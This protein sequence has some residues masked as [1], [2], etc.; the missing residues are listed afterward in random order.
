MQSDQ[1]SRTAYRVAEQRAAHQV[2]DVPQRT[3]REVVE[4]VDLPVFA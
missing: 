4:R 1:P 3:R 2:L